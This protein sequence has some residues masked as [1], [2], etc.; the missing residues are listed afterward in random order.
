MSEED[1]EKDEP[2]QESAAELLRS[3]S[4]AYAPGSLETSVNEQLIE[5]ALSRFDCVS[6]TDDTLRRAHERPVCLATV[7]P[8][9]DQRE[10]EAADQLRSALEGERE[11]PLMALAQALQAA[12]APSNL[13]RHQAAAA[14]DQ[15][16][17]GQARLRSSSTRALPYAMGVL[18]MAAGVTLWVSVQQQA[19]ISMPAARASELAQS[20]SLSPLFVETIEHASPTQ[21]IDRIYAVRSKELRQNRFATWRVR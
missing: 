3:L 13:E 1:R 16:L 9:P 15:A 12:Y 18:A 6:E 8:L 14:V 11:H 5:H 7:S 20:R 19:P 21:R 10:R 4:E 17:R 2:G